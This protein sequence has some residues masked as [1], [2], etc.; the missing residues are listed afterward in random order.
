MTSKRKGK[1][2]LDQMALISPSTKDVTMEESLEEF[3][4]HCQRLGLT[5]NT[6]INY[7]FT[8]SKKHISLNIAKYLH[9]NNMWFDFS[10][11]NQFSITE[12]QVYPKVGRK[13]KNFSKL[14]IELIHFH[15]F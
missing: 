3:L 12:K 8:E 15:S 13:E 1:L 14:I 11:A 9:N 2:S 4:R 10:K 7:M 6:V 5:K